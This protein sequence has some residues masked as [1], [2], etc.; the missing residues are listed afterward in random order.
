MADEITTT[1]QLSVASSGYTPG[2]VQANSIKIDQTTQGA[3]SG[4]MIVATSGSVVPVSDLT[5]PGVFFLKNLDAA[6]FCRYGTT[7]ASGEFLLNAGEACLSRAA[8]TT[9]NIRADTANVRVWYN[10]LDD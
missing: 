8:T 7:I 9:I 2:I 4:V 3:N 10:V 6:N 5:T 1:I